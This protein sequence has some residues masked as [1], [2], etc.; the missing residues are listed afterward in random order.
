MHV[1]WLEPLPLM[2]V[3]LTVILYIIVFY[4]YDSCEIK[5]LYSIK[6]IVW[7][8]ETWAFTEY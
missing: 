7:L 1:F 2:S 6:H 5:L 3:R 8:F 4:L